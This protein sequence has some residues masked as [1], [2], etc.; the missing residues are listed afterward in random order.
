MIVAQEGD[1]EG[2]LA[3]PELTPSKNL[4]ENLCSNFAFVLLCN[5]ILSS[6]DDGDDDNDD[7]D[8]DNS[9]SKSSSS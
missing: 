3:S 7:D 6:Q 5:V 8:D 2:D 4:E 1:Y 9:P